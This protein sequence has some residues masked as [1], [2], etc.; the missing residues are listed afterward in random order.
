MGDCLACES[1][2]FEVLQDR[3]EIKDGTMRFVIYLKCNL[4]GCGRIDYLPPTPYNP[5]DE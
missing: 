5:S 3:K 4:C 2:T 1:G